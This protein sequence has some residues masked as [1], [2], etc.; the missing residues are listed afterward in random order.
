MNRS[1]RV[2]KIVVEAI[3]PAPVDVVWKRSQDPE[4]HT[5]I[6]HDNWGRIDYVVLDSEMQLNIQQ[7]PKTFKII[8]DALA[9]GHAVKRAEFR[10]DEVVITIY[11]VKHTILPPTVHIPPQ[12]A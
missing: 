8:A 2:R 12:W 3:I 9:P 7:D 10:S 11:E 4:L 6:L 5:A 1:P